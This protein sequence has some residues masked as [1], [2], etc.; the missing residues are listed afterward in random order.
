M[1]L[2]YKTL[3]D[4][5]H[6][7][8]QAEDS[9]ATSPASSFGK[10]EGFVIDRVEIFPPFDVNGNLEELVVMLSVDDNLVESLRLHS[11]LFSPYLKNVH[12]LGLPL[13][14]PAS[15]NPV[16]N[17]CLKGNSKLQVVT[18]GGY[19][20]VTGDY[21]VK[22]KGYYVDDD[23]ALQR[24][25]GGSVFNPIP[26]SIYDVIR[27]KT[28]TINKPVDV[29]VDNLSK[30]PSGA[31][32]AGVPYVMPYS[33]WARNSKAT[34]VNQPY[35]LD[36]A[37]GNVANDYESMMWNLKETEG[38]FLTH[39]AFQEHANSKYFFFKVGTEEIPD[40]YF[41]VADGS[42]ELPFSTFDSPRPLRHYPI[43]F[44]GEKATTYIQD[45][46]TSIPADG[47]VAWIYGLKIKLA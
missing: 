3:I 22:V 42:N 7:G 46:G 38:V 32:G 36:V 29:S 30:M 12:N 11:S 13:G 26:A 40:S 20:G 33:T 35:A 43:L 39:L 10:G 1:K 27:N 34:T 8:S 9:K 28:I 2:D 45:N 21:R 44:T 18:Y 23:M 25:F 47:I 37:L 5:S 15:T 24:L 14:D 31:P 4:F 16:K 6:T 17:T 19:G 41:D